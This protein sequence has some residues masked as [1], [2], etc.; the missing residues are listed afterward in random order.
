MSMESRG[1]TMHTKTRRG[2]TSL[3]GMTFQEVSD[4]LPK[5]KAD[6]TVERHGRV[7]GG[8]D[9]RPN[10]NGRMQW[11][12]WMEDET[13]AEKVY[14]LARKGGDLAEEERQFLAHWNR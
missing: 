4:R 3:F 9:K 7:V 6:A 14:R 10:D 8:V 1:Y 12:W 2:W 11:Y 5:T 13:P